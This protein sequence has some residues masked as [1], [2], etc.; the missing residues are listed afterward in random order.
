MADLAVLMALALVRDLIFH[1]RFV[2][3]GD[4]TAT[5]PPFGRS[6][7]S[8]RVGIVGLGHIGTAIARRLAPFGCEIA[9]W[10]PRDK[11]DVQWPRQPALADL[12]RWSNVLMVAARAEATSR[13]LISAEVIEALG[14]GGFLVNVS[15]GFVMDEAALKSAL[16][17]GRLGGAALEVFARE[18]ALGS[19]WADVPN[20]LLT[21]HVGGAT[22]GSIRAAIASA[23]DNVRRHFEGEPLLHRVA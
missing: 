9:W 3:S 8:Q 23:V 10:G 11:P 4:W 7:S 14:A 20:L 2:R 12:A 17:A 5:P 16:K 13:G 6:M 21:P 15:R 18:P 22:M 19:D 1:D